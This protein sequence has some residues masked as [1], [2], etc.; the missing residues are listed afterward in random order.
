M[1]AE[2]V[3]SQ[4]GYGWSITDYGLRV[5]R[6]QKFMYDNLPV[7]RTMA[8]LSWRLILLAILLYE[9]V[10]DLKPINS[11]PKI[12]FLSTQQHAYQSFFGYFLVLF[13]LRPCDTLGEF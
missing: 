2:G 7:Q 6:S 3:E 4:V 10:I 12:Q 9:Q 5:R 11:R 13:R 8:I 1:N